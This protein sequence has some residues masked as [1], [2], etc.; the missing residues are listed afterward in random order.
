MAEGFVFP[1]RSEVGPVVT[2]CVVLPPRLASC[3]GPTCAPALEAL[4]LVRLARPVPRRLWTT[5]GLYGRA[6]GRL[7]LATDDGGAYFTLDDAAVALYR[8]AGPTQA[9]MVF[10]G[11][12][13][14]PWLAQDA[15]APGD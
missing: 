11:T 8:Q 5:P 9:R 13:D 14:P 10:N 6:F 3:C 12:R 2:R 1:F 15:F 4:V 7:S